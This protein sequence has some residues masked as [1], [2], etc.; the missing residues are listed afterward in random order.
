MLDFGPFLKKWE[1]GAVLANLLEIQVSEG[2]GKSH[3]L[4]ASA[5]DLSPSHKAL[6]I[7]LWAAGWPAARSRTGCPPAHR[8]R[9]GKLQEPMEGWGAAAGG[10]SIWGAAGPQLRGAV[11]VAKLWL[12]ACQGRD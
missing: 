4:I 6:I 7:C 2:K 3:L 11:L 12:N 8:K 10:Q 5:V 1:A 9:G